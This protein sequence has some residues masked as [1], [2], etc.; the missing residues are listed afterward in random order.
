MKIGICIPNYGK[1]TSKKALDEFT[2]IAEKMDYESIWTTDHL[3]IPKEF[4]SPYGSTIE[5]LASLSYL[6]AKTENVKLG[7]SIIIFPM[8]EAVLLARQAAAIQILSD[9]R[10]LLGLGAG[11][12]KEEF[13]NLRSD[14]ASRGQYYDEGIQLFRWLMKGNSEFKGDFYSIEDGVFGPVPK[15]NIP[16][17]IGGNGGSAL[18]RAAKLGD[19]WFP[20]GLSPK[21]IAEGKEKLGSRTERKLEIL[22]RLQVEFSDKKGTSSLTARGARGDVQ[23]RLAGTPDEIHSQIEAY[24][25]AGADRIVCYFGDKDL[26]SLSRAATKFGKELVSSI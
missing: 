12:N 13:R 24:R 17:Y 4:A 20:V 14:F 7:T 19:G 25:K 9:N 5:S 2:T 26:N 18:R 11:W 16:I 8:R 10:L 22:V 23:N 21:E 3:L 6:A 15:K 1:A